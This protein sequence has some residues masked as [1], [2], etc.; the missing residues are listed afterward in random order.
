[1]SVMATEA[2]KEQVVRPYKPV[3]PGYTGHTVVTTLNY[4]KD[5]GDGS[6]P[7]PVLVGA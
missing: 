6:P 7:T 2:T 4:Y 3:R 1:M 5:P